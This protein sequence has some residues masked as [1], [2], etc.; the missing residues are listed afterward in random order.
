MDI[1]FDSHLFIGPFRVWV[2]RIVFLLNNFVEGPILCD[3][4]E[5]AASHNKRIAWLDG[6]LVIDREDLRLVR[7]EWLPQTIVIPRS[8][9]ARVTVAGASQGHILI[10]KHQF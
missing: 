9:E 2:V 8:S 1:V 10:A 7:E 6:L 4:I 3:P 5:G